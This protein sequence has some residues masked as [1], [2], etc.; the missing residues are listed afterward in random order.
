MFCPPYFVRYEGI[1]LRVKI[2]VGQLDSGGFP[3]AY[4]HHLASGSAPGDFKG[5][6]DRRLSQRK[7]VPVMDNST[8]QAMSDAVAGHQWKQ[9]ENATRK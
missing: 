4:P 1:N 7:A 8:F 2:I 6:T 3:L 5:V 9:I